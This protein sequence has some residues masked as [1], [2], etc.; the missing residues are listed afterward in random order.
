[1]DIVSRTTGIERDYLKSTKALGHACIAVKMSW[2]AN[3]ITTREEDMA[4]AMLGLLDVNMSLLYGEGGVNA[5]RR[6]QMKLIA[7]S[8]DESIFAW[9]N[10]EEASYES[11][12]STRPVLA[13]S[14]SDFAGCGSLSQMKNAGLRRIISREPYY[15]TNRGIKF[16]GCA[17]P[18]G[19]G[20]ERYQLTKVASSGSCGQWWESVRNDAY[21]VP[22]NCWDLNF[23]TNLFGE[24]RRC[25]IVVTDAKPSITM[26]K[27]HA[28]KKT[29]GFHRL[30]WTTLD[31]PIKEKITYWT[32]YDKVYQFYLA[33]RQ[34]MA[35]GGLGLTIGTSTSD[36]FVH[37][38]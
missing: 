38:A 11:V 14:P 3:R 34:E 31:P 30:L 15:T 35:G 28:A 9:G 6:V 25:H 10:G 8:S 24:P 29:E 19:D 1:M 16:G 20:S 32:P 36:W 21:L 26:G 12:T 13:A 5:F 22:L 2:M 18:L 37:R 7:Q 23:S 4:Y 33:Y 27:F 17:V